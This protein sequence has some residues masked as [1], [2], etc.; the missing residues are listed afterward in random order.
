MK[1]KTILAVVILI[2]F[3]GGIFALGKYRLPSQAGQAPTT[4][5]TP[6]SPTPPDTSSWKSTTSS[7][8]TFKYPETLNTTYMHALDWPPQVQV[9]EGPF[10]CTNAGDEAARAGV[11]QQKTINGHSY[12]V[13]TVTEGAAGST[14]TQYAYAAQRASKTLYFTFTIQATQCGNYS[15]PQ[16]SACAKERSSFNIDQIMDQVITTAQI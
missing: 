16:M 6:T 7:G 15:E 12:C 1:N 9:I 3:F 4:S 10:V 8:V 5:N 2:I 11:T 14:Y 13:T